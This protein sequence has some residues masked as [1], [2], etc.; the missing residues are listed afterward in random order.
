MGDFDKAVAHGIENM[1]I[2]DLPMER[3]LVD[4][5]HYLRHNIRYKLDE[6]SRKAMQMFTRYSRELNEIHTNVAPNTP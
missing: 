3:E 1:D 5:K 2:L 6:G 4:I